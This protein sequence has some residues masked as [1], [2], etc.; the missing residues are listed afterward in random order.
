MGDLKQ[1]IRRE[2]ARRVSRLGQA[3]RSEK[4][5]AIARRL[6]ALPEYAS[7]KTG[8]FFH[9]LPDEVITTRILSAALAR[10][11]VAL[12]RCDPGARGSM[13]AYEV[14]D[15]KRDLARGS[16]GLMEP[17]AAPGRLIRPQALD[18][19]VTPGRAFDPAG[20][21]LGRGEGYYDA[22][23]A[24]IEDAG[25]RAAVIALAFECQIVE[26]V[27]AGPRDLPV[28]TIVTEERVIRP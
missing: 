13:E 27:P 26:R 25:G 24:R 3:E 17:T 16:Y 28:H 9:H 4:S 22:Y 19:V 14:Q 7:A 6:E 10:M 5:A 20:G 11:R 12:P 21:R 1:R 18:V 23:L 8:L 2:V 15:L